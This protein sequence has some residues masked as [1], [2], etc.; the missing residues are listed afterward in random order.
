MKAVIVKARVSYWD[1]LGKS[2]ITSRGYAVAT[3]NEANLQWQCQGRNGL[4]YGRTPE[5][6]VEGASLNQFGVSH[7]YRTRYAAVKA[8]VPIDAAGR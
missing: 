6:A 7:G 4:G 8:S 5:A 2:R 3:W 1:K